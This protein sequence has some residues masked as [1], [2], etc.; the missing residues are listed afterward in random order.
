LQSSRAA[1]AILEALSL[2]ST[3]LVSVAVIVASCQVIG[4]FDD[5]AFEPTSVGGTGGTGGGAAAGGSGGMQGACGVRPPLKVPSDGVGT[6]TEF[7]VALRKLDFGEDMLSDGP[8]VGYDLD[9]RCS[10]EGDPAGEVSDPGCVIPDYVADPGNVCD[11]PRGRDNNM[12]KLLGGAFGLA[13]SSADLSAAAERGEATALFHV[14]EYNGLPNDDQV[15]V[16]V[17]A[18]DDLDAEP[19]FTPGG[20]GAGGVPGGAQIAQWDGEDVWPVLSSSVKESMTGEQMCPHPDEV[21]LAAYEDPIAYVSGGVLVASLAEAELFIGGVNF[22]TPIRLTSSFVT[23]KLEN[24]NGRWHLRDGIITGRW[25]L[26]DIFDVLAY[27]KFGS[28]SLCTRDPLYKALRQ[29]ICEHVDISSSP[30]VPNPGC[31][32]LS[33]AL[34]IEADPARI[35][36]VVDAPALVDDCSRG[37]SPMD[38]SCKNIK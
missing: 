17:Y 30:L 6:P 7:T 1:R 23:G 4:G 12:A 9:E 27:A 16:A 3:I 20:G 24:V 29:A 13:I 31:D 37:E 32:A 10:C 38:D 33:Y 34:A 11:G 35:G 5:L 28:A 22:Q 25:A 19:C 14:S 8:L 18:A 15:T 26:P 36:N 21:P 2:R